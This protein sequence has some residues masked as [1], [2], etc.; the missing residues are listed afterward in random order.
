MREFFDSMTAVKCK[1]CGH[2]IALINGNVPEVKCDSCG[3]IRKLYYGEKRRSIQLM[4]K[5]SV[6]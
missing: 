5:G 6:S 2:T 1:H 4:V 3:R